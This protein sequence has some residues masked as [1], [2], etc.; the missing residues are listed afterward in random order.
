MGR[1]GD[2]ELGGGGGGNSG[3][4]VTTAEGESYAE[5][6]YNDT[7]GKINPEG[8]WIIS[9][10]KWDVQEA[11]AFEKKLES[12]EQKKD[13]LQLQ[14]KWDK[15]A[16]VNAE[17]EALKQNYRQN[18]SDNSY[19]I[20]YKDGSD[21][22][23]QPASDSVSDKNVKLGNI[24]YVQYQGVG[25]KADTLGANSDYSGTDRKQAR[26]SQAFGGYDEFEDFAMGYD[27]EIDR[28]YKTDWGRRHPR[29][30]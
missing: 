22:I 1:K 2:S 17:I 26:L 8:D 13:K 14:G 24:A 21:V 25:N 18:V 16:D 3:L 6:L 19:W 29:T 5:Q 28:L 9:E 30:R 12:L 10:L 4:Y 15:I 11:R 23:Y 27:D 20:I 7:N